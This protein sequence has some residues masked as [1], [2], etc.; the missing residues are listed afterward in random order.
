MTII[1]INLTIFNKINHIPL[2]ISIDYFE[3]I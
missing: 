2:I 1:T 3:N